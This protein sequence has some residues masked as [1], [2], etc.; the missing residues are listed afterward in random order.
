M[1][2][3][4]SG[5]DV[6]LLDA[7]FWGATPTASHGAAPSS[8]DRRQRTSVTCRRSRGAERISTS[9]RPHC[10]VT[11]RVT[12]SRGARHREG[13]RTTAFV[14]PPKPI[15]EAGHAP[16]DPSTGAASAAGS[17]RLHTHVLERGGEPPG[18][19]AGHGH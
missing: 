9:F 6:T 11:L 18:C 1:S 8:F 5:M 10:Y 15:Q 14:V 7:R 4:V 2:A 16:D 3:R 12:A 17:G 19:G 13:A